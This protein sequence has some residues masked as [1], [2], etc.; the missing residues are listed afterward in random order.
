[1]NEADAWV[2]FAAA[3]LDHAVHLRDPMAL[4]V[5]GPAA[6]YA[7]AAAE[8]GHVADAMLIELR[9]RQTHIDAPAGPAIE[10]VPSPRPEDDSEEANPLPRYHELLDALCLRFVV[11]GGPTF[12][13]ALD[14]IEAHYVR[15]AE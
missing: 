4:D 2:G 3:T 12:A 11:P 10:I 14:W 5:D 9:K 1:M 7:L 15:R 8:V 6:A 13:E